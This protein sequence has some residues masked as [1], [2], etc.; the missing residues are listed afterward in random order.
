MHDNFPDWYRAAKIEP[1]PDNILHRWTGVEEYTLALLQELFRT[2]RENE[3]IL[4]FNAWKETALD[5]SWATQ[6]P[7]VTLRVFRFPNKLLNFCLWYLQFPKLDRLLGGNHKAEG[8]AIG[9]G[10]LPRDA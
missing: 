5:F 10:R 8:R 7:N 1:N 6:Y 9:I 4:F 2:D 3:Y